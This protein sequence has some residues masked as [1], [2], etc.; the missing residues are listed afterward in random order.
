MQILGRRNSIGNGR[1]IGGCLRH[2]LQGEDFIRH[3]GNDK[4]IFDFKSGSGTVV[5]DRSREG[6]D[7]T[8]GAGAAAPTWKRNSLY[9][10]GGDYVDCGDKPSLQ[11]TDELT[12]II[13]VNHSVIADTLGMIQ[14]NDVYGN[15]GY[16]LTVFATNNKFGFYIDENGAG[17]WKSIFSDNVVTANVWNCLIATF[18]GTAKLYQ[19][20]FLQVDVDTATKITYANA[21]T[22]IGTYKALY[23]TGYIKN[24]RILNKGLS[25]IECQQEY[26]CQKWRGN[27]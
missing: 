20:S 24:V 23:M 26:L 7:G 27:C 3:C 6:N 13:N 2:A 11:P 8:F 10:D 1:G 5:K 17:N 22:K 18:D 14:T 16:L 12:L 19:D 15:N 4:L 25:G 9:F 21:T